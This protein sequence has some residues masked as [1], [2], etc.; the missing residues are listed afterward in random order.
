[1]ASFDSIEENLSSSEH[2]SQLFNYLTL[3]SEV[4]T[5]TQGENFL[6]SGKNDEIPKEN[7][8]L[9]VTL[10]DINCVLHPQQPIDTSFYW[11]LNS[12]FGIRPQD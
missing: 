7:P 10:A 11:H 9:T 12:R 5:S 4:T 8:T 6:S 3:N 2:L 1:M